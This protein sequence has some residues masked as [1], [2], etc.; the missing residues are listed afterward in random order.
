MRE[1]APAPAGEP[2]RPTMDIGDF[3]AIAMR[4]RRLLAPCLAIAGALCLGYLA[5][6]PTRYTASM[7]LLVD[8]RERVP[9]GVDAAPMPQN[10]DAA[11][12]ESQMR[13]LTSKA[14]LRRVVDAR[15]LASDPALSL[16]HI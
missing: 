13:I 16:I 14:V 6:T 15:G 3:A 11:L 12:V 4:R 5:L 9:L 1:A 8:P 2:G 7:S 10:P